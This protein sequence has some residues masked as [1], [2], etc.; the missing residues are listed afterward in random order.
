MS[1]TGDSLAPDLAA[2]VVETI[3][4]VGPL[5]APFAKLGAQRISRE[6]ARKNSVALRAAERSSGMTRED[7]ADK[8]SED[9]RLIPL[10]TRVLFAAGMTGKDT[11]LRALGTALGDAVRDPDN[12]DEAELLLISMTNLRTQHLVILEILSEDPPQPDDPRN[13]TYWHRE[14]IAAKSDYRRDLVDLCVSGL[15]GSGLISQL[16]DTYG[17]CYQITELG[18]TA[19]AVVDQLD[20]EAT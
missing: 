19:L 4:F 11:I 13:R 5:M 17:V 8:L 18:Q 15:V 1:A 14:L 2:G 7:L 3:P 16:D 12:I 9:P 20:E 6:W 10:V